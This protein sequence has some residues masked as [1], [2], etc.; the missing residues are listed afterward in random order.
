M[1]CHLFGAEPLP[2]PVQYKLIINRILR[3]KLQW[4]C[5]Q[6]TNIFIQENFDCKVTT[7]CFWD[8]MYHPTSDISFTLIDN[9]TVDHSDVAGA[10][11]VGAAPTTFSLMT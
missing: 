7:F 9:K 11:P 8:S 3:N 10:W 5:N 4:N 2:E 6:H 1:A